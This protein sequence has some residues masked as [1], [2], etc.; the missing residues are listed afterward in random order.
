MA[1][2]G[3]QISTTTSAPGQLALRKSR[4]FCSKIQSRGT[5]IEMSAGQ[6]GTDA[7]LIDTH[8]PAAPELWEPP[9]G[10]ASGFTGG[11]SARRKRI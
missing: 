6:R 9:S 10:L 3:A 7:G 4:L 8:A 1:G 11:H 2:G 5:A